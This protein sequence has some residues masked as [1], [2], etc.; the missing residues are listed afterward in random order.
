[1]NLAASS[2]ESS[3]LFSWTTR[4]GHKRQLRYVIA[5]EAWDV[6]S[7]VCDPVTGE[8]AGWS[9]S[10]PLDELPRAE[11]HDQAR[12]IAEHFAEEKP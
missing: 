2:T 10:M 4:D 5:R 8:L 11:N 9:S 3:W 6:T 12:E 7:R 1:M